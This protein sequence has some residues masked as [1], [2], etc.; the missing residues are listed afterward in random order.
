[1]ELAK[2]RDM[3][4]DEG[5][6]R[7]RLNPPRIFL[8]SLFIGLPEELGSA[9]GRLGMKATIALISASL[10]WSS[11]RFLLDL[12]RANSWALRLCKVGILCQSCIVSGGCVLA[13]IGF[14]PGGYASAFSVF[15]LAALPFTDDGNGGT[16][17]RFTS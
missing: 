5:F 8:L 14:W 11:F 1:M 4:S 12:R 9:A 17:G 13:R 7:L 6:W 2:G 3:L 15:D 16:G 10:S